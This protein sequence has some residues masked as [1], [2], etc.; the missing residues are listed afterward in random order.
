MAGHAIEPSWWHDADAVEERRALIEAFQVEDLEAATADLRARCEELERRQ[1]DREPVTV[2]DVAQVLLGQ[3]SVSFQTM[4][5]DAQ[6][7]YFIG[8]EY[9]RLVLAAQDGRAA[10][11]AVRDRFLAPDRI[12]ARLLQAALTLANTEAAARKPDRA[13]ALDPHRRRDQGWG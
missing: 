5:A 11:L 4:L 1:R 12:D 13:S 10:A 8:G 7:G 6:R 2:G 3:W 9:D